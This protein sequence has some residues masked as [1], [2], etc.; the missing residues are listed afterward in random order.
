[1]F[2]REFFLFPVNFILLHGELTLFLKATCLRPT[3]KFFFPR[4]VVY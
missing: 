3:L 1:L 2:S 4:E